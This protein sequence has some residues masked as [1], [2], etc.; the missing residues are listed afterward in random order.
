[1]THAGNLG[2]VPS[3]GYAIFSRCR[4]DFRGVERVFSVIAHDGVDKA[5]RHS[6]Q[7]SVAI[8]FDL[9][10]AGQLRPLV[11]LAFVLSGSRVVAEDIV[12]DALLAAFKNWNQVGHMDNPAGWVRRVVAN[13]AVSATR[14]RLIEARSSTKF[15]QP[16]EA[17]SGDA[18]ASD[19]EHVWAEVRRLPKRQAQVITLRTLDLSTIAEIAD[20]LGISAESASTHLRRARH[21]L[22]SRLTPGDLQ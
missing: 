6:P 13:R 4:T 11:G 10:F 1:M 14:R 22:A 9:F 7:M 18:T 15:R 19:N 8:D 5:M 17:T 20:V 16:T 21:T 2:Q 3:D 12:Q